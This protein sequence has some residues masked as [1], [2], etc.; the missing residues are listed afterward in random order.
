MYRIL[1]IGYC[2]HWLHIHVWCWWCIQHSM[3][4][5]EPTENTHTHTTHTMHH[6]C[7]HVC[8][9]ITPISTHHYT[10]LSTHHYTPI[11]THHYTP[12]STHHYTQTHTM[13]GKLTDNVNQL[14]D[15]AGL[16]PRIFQYLFQRIEELQGALTM[17]VCAVCCACVV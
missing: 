9:H 10:P 11:S 5:I 2:V 8:L 3:R 7:V 16:V 13:I 6:T 17:P 15:Q 12:L 1:C 14:P 4:C